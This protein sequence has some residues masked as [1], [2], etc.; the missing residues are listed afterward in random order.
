MLTKT[1]AAGRREDQAKPRTLG[2]L[3]MDDGVIAFALANSSLRRVRKRARLGPAGTNPARRNDMRL[4]LRFALFACELGRRAAEWHRTDTGRTAFA[5]TDRRGE[6]SQGNLARAEPV[7]GWG[8][9]L[10]PAFMPG[11][12]VVG[13]S[14]AWGSW[15]RPEP[16]VG[17]MQGHR[18]SLCNT[19]AKG[20]THKAAAQSPK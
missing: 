7:G 20:K 9:V 19:V 18:L 10:D 2:P 16:A 6:G 14:A 17:R 13:Y 5:Q 3:V 11:S 4:R 8:T 12:R 1:C 15:G